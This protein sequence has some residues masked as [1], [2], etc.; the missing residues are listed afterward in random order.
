MT[1]FP[2]EKS[3]LDWK[4]RRGVKHDKDRASYRKPD[5]TRFYGPRNAAVFKPRERDYCHRD[6]FEKLLNKDFGRR[7]DLYDR[8]GTVQDEAELHAEYID[9]QAELE[10][11]ARLKEWKDAAIPQWL[12]ER[13]FLLDMID[14]TE[15]IK[16][17]FLPFFDRDGRQIFFIVTNAE[18]RRYI[19]LAEDYGLRI[20][21]VPESFAMVFA[22]P[23]LYH[24]S[25]VVSDDPSTYYCLS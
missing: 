7:A 3:Y 10:Q 2:D 15:E 19:S 5:G 4:R 16:P 1:I 11:P 13:N 18:E 17:F 9:R 14:I 20:Y 24:S 8:F 21:P 25:H 23:I 22:V 6:V 12:N